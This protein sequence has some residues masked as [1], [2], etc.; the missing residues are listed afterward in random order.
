MN[1]DLELLVGDD[2]ADVLQDEV[3]GD[4]AALGAHTPALA[5]RHEALERRRP[6]V[7]LDALVLAP[8]P[9]Q[10]NILC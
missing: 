2:F 8:L 6:L 7:P 5:L 1:T 3:T 4:D 10:H 9:A